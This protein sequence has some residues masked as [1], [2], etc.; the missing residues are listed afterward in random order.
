[1]TLMLFLLLKSTGTKQAI[2]FKIMESAKIK[3]VSPF[4]LPDLYLVWEW[5][6]AVWNAVSDDFTPRDVNEFIKFQ[7]A[8]SQLPNVA[9]W[10]VYANDEIAGYVRVERDP[11]RDWLCEAH[12][13][14]KKSLWGRRYGVTDMSLI[15]IAQ[16]VF[17]N[18]IERIGMTIFDSNGG[19]K[20]LAKRIGAV[21]EGCLSMQ[22]RKN[23]KYVNTVVYALTRERLQQAK[24]NDYAN[25]STNSSSIDRTGGEHRSKSSGATGRQFDTDLNSELHTGTTAGH[26]DAGQNVQQTIKSGETAKE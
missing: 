3:I 7:S 8:W 20:A 24:E 9:T 22:T 12:C 19:M 13:I 26:A 4:P 6:Q 5:A 23:E 25:G 1:M 14:F 2:G 21:E 16:E 10:A 18:G 15:Q 17:D 11:L